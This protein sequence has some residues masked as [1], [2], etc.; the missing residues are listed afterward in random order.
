MRILTMSNKVLCLDDHRPHI[1]MVTPDRNAQVIPVSVFV[2]IAKG[3]LSV[4]S[5]GE[6]RDMILRVIFKDWLDAYYDDRK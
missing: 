6:D 5:F 1:A 2:K 4:D 3:E